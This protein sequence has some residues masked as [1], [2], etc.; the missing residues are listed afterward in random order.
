MCAIAGR[1]IRDLIHGYIPVN[2]RDLDFIDTPAFQRLKRIRQTSAF[3]VY[4][5]NNHTRFE[6]S[7][8]VMN[9]GVAAAKNLLGD[10]CF[11]D[12]ISNRVDTD[13]I[14]STVRYACLLHDI[15]HPPLSHLGERF[16]DKTLLIKRLESEINALSS[17]VDINAEGAAS[18]EIASC[19]IS[20][21]IFKQNLIDLGVDLEFFCRLIIGQYYPG[22]SDKVFLNPFIKILSSDF[23]VDKLDFVLRDNLM[24]GGEML[25]LDKNRFV[26]AYCYILQNHQLGLSESALSTIAN[27]V[28]GRNALYEWVYNHH[29]TVYADEIIARLIDYIS[30]KDAA[31]KNY[32]SLDGLLKD[33]SDD[34]DVISFVKKYV[35]TS[36]P[37]R[38]AEILYSQYFERKFYKPLWKSPLQ[39]E[40]AITHEP[41]RIQFVTEIGKHRGNIEQ[42]E[43]IIKEE[44]SA[45][46]GDFCL[47]LAKYKPF[48]PSTG[49]AVYVKLKNGSSIGFDKI[50]QKS[51]YVNSYSELAYVFINREKYNILKPKI[52]DYISNK[53]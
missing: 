18:H 27:L 38:R 7:L 12:N 48:V 1:I 29:V 13:M 47:S 8:G 9:L 15:G 21:N 41:A 35:K 30:E 22:H 39:F 45:D 52:I 17:P 44:L 31:L 11:K 37:D 2:D 14:E 24:A 6:H 36:G 42:L 40:R 46:Q 49:K 4:P 3:Q 23:D 19:I 32:F 33:H 5:S 10:K 20:L 16:L 28:Y 51:I 50:F 25:A 34:H 26:S 43:S 53:F